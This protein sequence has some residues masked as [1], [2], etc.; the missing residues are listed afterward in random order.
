VRSCKETEGGDGARVGVADSA[1]R[2]AMRGG[3]GNGSGNGVGLA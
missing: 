1:V 2:I 3:G